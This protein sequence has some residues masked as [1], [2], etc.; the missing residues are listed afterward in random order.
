MSAPLKILAVGNSFSVDAMQ[1]LAQVANDLGTPVILGNLYIGGCS[2]QR[3]YDNSLSGIRD[4]TYYKTTDGNWTELPESDINTGLDDEDWDIVTMQQA[5]HYSGAPET[6]TCL[7]LLI[8]Y[9]KAHCPHAKLLWHMTWAYQNDS[10][11]KHFPR[12]NRDQSRMYNAIVDCLGLFV[13]AAG[14]YSAVIPTGTAVQNARSGFLGD[15]LT[16][17]GFHL[18]YQIGRLLGAM[19]WYAAITGQSVDALTYTPDPEIVTPEILALLKES[20]RNAIASPRTV[21]PSAR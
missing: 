20:V 7:P 9:I 8:D 15:T 1:F 6:F 2:L 16:R 3:H 21:T 12:Y 4:Y 10:P 11:H 18:S 13:D 5:S 19:T 14:A 17:D